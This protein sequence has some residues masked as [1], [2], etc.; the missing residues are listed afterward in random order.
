VKAFQG[1]SSLPA[2]RS[3]TSSD[4]DIVIEA[5]KIPTSF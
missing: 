1:D 5:K 4:G 2:L 3:L